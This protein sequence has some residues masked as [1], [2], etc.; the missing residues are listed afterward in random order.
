[1]TDKNQRLSEWNKTIAEGENLASEIRSKVIRMKDG[2]PRR[3]F[4]RLLNFTEKWIARGKK[5][6]NEELFDE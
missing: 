2:I 5:W 6:R 1:M 4:L 3:V